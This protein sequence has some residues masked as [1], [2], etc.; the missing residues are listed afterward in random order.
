M[1]L[2]KFYLQHS[3][4]VN[5]YRVVYCDTEKEAQN[6]CTD[7]EFV[8]DE[9]AWREYQGYMGETVEE[10]DPWED[11]DDI[12][13]YLARADGIERTTT[14]PTAPP[15]PDKWMEAFGYPVDPLPRWK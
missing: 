8:L 4:L 5:K 13:G 12:L 2:H 15:R 3:S 1:M 6:D 14:P 11:G 10:I 7:E 9:K